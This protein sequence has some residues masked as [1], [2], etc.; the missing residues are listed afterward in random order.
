MK[1]FVS[2]VTIMVRDYDEAIAYYT[3]ALGF[4]IAEDAPQT[5]GKRWVLVRPPGAN[6]CGLLLAKAK[7]EE[8]RK[9]VGCQAGGRVCFFLHTDDLVRDYARMKAWGVRFR[10]E[11]RN[12]PYG[13]VAVFEDLYGNKWDLIQPSSVPEKLVMRR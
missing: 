9:A 2:A 5:A 7:N 13:R 11:P 3:Q 10:E 6:E 4:E 12:E 8:E 1:Q